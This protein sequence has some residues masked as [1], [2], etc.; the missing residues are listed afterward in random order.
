VTVLTN[1]A[2]KFAVIAGSPQA[3]QAE[4]LNDCGVP[5]TAGSVTATFSTG[6]APV[7]MIATGAGNW[8]GTW[9]P[10]NIGGGAASVTITANSTAAI[11]AG[12]TVTAGSLAENDSVPMMAA[13]SPVVS[14]ASFAAG[15]PL[16]PGTFVTILG[17]NLGSGT[18]AV[19]TAPFPPTLAGT[20]VLMG[21]EP[22]PLYYV[23]GQQIN[24]V[25]PW[26]V[27]VNA[28]VP[29]AVQFNGMA[30]M[31]VGVVTAAATPAVFTQDESGS[32]LGS[33][34]VIKPSGKVYVAS[35]SNTASAG[36]VLEVYCVGL[37]AVDSPPPAGAPAS[38]TTLARTIT[39]V[40]AT[41][42]GVPATVSFSGLAPGYAGL[43]QVNVTVPAGVTPG[44]AV[45]I[46]LQEGN[47]SSPPVTIPIQ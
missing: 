23:G 1:L 9:M 12:S 44:P 47:F 15:Q 19:A 7:T 40:T 36:D 4:V 2:D 31:P 21:G 37:G 41:I 29:L 39:P 33:I 14:A 32:G 28:T 3:L 8:A 24:A 10:H 38:T 13:I 35:A 22:L 18:G 20:Q 45:A 6:D 34:V 27:P 43:Y 42:G 16:A 5:L 11:A 26:D 17:P 46:V 30:S 25:I